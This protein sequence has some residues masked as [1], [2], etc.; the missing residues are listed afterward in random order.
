MAV[1]IPIITEFVGDGI[2]KA[3][4]EFK[5]LEG[6]GAKAAYGIKK[7]ALPAT[8]ALA[9]LG[10]MLVDATKGAI[11]DA[12]A[13]ELLAG[14]LRRATG[15]T[16]EQIAAVEEWIGLQGQLL[17]IADDDLRPALSKLARAT[18]SVTKAQELAA[19]AMDIAA[20]TGKPLEGVIGAL[21]KAY[22]GN[23]GA[24]K[25]LAPEYQDL[26]KDGATF[27]EVMDAI[28][29]TTGGAATDAADT[30]AGR[31][32]RMKLSLDETK[33]SIGAALLPA[34]EAMLPFLQK[35]S[36]WAQKNPQLLTAL[37]IGFSGLAAA[38]IAVNIAMMA[39]PI[40]LIVGAIV[41]LVAGIVVAYK[42]FETF[43]NIVDTMF[44]GFTIGFNMVKNYFTS[45]AGFY[46]TIFNGIASAWNN[47]IGKLSFRVPSWVPGI[48]GKG[49]DV[50]EI[51]MLANGG[52]VTGP[53]LAM[54]GEAGPEAVIPLDR[55]GAVGGN[56]VTINV[57][58]G[59]PQQV[60]DALRRYMQL[61]GSVPI[62]VSA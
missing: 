39:N 26:I 15:A 45:V 47:T 46:K 28:A 19:A 31:F 6:A 22:G 8:A 35:F 29:F 50:P 13:Q 48:G 62:R 52:I 36:D 16:D 61:N 32:K 44:D 21:E 38:I 10:A 59:D 33:E 17:G 7:A 60:V 24:L 43:R 25:K 41:A 40:S 12:A 57:N 5:Q 9:G 56:K 18:G 37:I 4:Q 20:A 58:G 27:E 42:K 23:V 2:K 53:T 14:N 3:Q 11:D 55:M 54:I 51:P 49:F 34:V 1:S 30:A